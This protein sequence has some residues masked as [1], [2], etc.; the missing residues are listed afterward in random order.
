MERPL[1]NHIDQ[2]KARV[3]P[4]P[5]PMTPE[6]CLQAGLLG[7][8]PQVDEEIALRLALPCI[9]SAPPDLLDTDVGVGGVSQRPSDNKQTDQATE[10]SARAHL[11]QGGQ[12]QRQQQKPK[13]AKVAGSPGSA[14]GFVQKHRQ[15]HQA[16]D[17]ALHKEQLPAL[18][19]PARPRT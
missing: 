5:P 8:L 10:D 6:V 14:H 15:P 3:D 9:S 13:Q 4:F 18:Q 2:Y 12:H 17:K 11:D 19:R 1:K 7:A 16:A